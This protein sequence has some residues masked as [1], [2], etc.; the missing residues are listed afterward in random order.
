VFTRT[1]SAP[2]SAACRHCGSE[3]LTRLF[4]RVAV[5][6][7]DEDGAP[8]DESSL[9]EVDESDPR[10]VARWVRK[11]S[12]QMGE[13][14]DAAMEADLERLEAGETLEDD[15]GAEAEFAEVD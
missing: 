8:F 2:V 9:G 10:S 13:P 1:V 15:G 6:R 5:L 12:R 3:R 14:L 11:M 7:A 4:S